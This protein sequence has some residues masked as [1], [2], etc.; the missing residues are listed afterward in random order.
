MRKKLSGILL[1]LIFVLAGCRDINDM[2]TINSESSLQCVNFEINTNNPLL[3]L[4]LTTGH[5]NDDNY[6]ITSSLFEAEK[7]VS[8]SFPNIEIYGSELQEKINNLIWN[9]VQQMLN[10][11]PEWNE[12]TLDV[13]YEIKFSSD[14]LLSIVYTG[15]GFVK[16]SARPTHLFYALNINMETGEKIILDDVVIID[17]KFIELLLSD[18]ATHLNSCLELK[19]FVKEIISE[20]AFLLRLRSTANSMFYFTSDSLGISIDGLGGAAGDHAELEVRY[21]AL[22]SHLQSN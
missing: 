20:E 1:I 17:E 6:T 9:E 2:E 3:L 21:E 7:N 13:Q 5:T 22:T 10:I 16:G 14:S 4:P 15:V 11:F 18:N 8:I 19:Q 12:L